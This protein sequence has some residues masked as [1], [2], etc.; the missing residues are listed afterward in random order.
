MAGRGRLGHRWSGLI[1]PAGRAATSNQSRLVAGGVASD[2]VRAEIGDYPVFTRLSPR[3]DSDAQFM[4]GDVFDAVTLHGTLADEQLSAGRVGITWRAY[5][6]LPLVELVI[7][8]DKD[9]VEL[10]EAAYVAFP[11]QTTNDC[12]NLETS[13][14][15]FQPGSHAPGGQLPGTV[16][17]YYTMQRAAQIES[18]DGGGLFWLPLEAPLVMLQDLNFIN[19]DRRPYEWNGFLASMPVNHYWHTNFPRSQ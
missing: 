8:W 4:A 7:D 1:H 11:F 12:L 13:G 16:S 15:F 18:P 5:H 2:K 10:P 14:G 19:W 6:A 9:W 3:I 17:S